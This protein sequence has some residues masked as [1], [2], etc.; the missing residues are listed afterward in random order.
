ME[1][2]RTLFEKSLRQ[3]SWHVKHV[4]DAKSNQ[5]TFYVWPAITSAKD[6]DA[7]VESASKSFLDQL[8]HFK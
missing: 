6:V 4:Y 5:D 1:N 3:K 8:Q 7:A 2:L